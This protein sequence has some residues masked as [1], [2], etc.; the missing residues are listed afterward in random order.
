MSRFFSEKYNAL[1]AYTPGEQPKDMQYVKLNTNESPFPP[2]KKAKEYAAKALDRLQ[3]YCDPEC[4][5][6]TKEFAKLYGIGED[7]VVFTN[8]S[9]DALNFCFMAFCDRDTGAA[10]PDITYGFYPVF[11]RLNGV[12]YQEIPLRDDFTI[13]VDDYIGVNKTI[14]IANPNAPTGIALSLDDIER[15]L[16]GN[17]DNIVVV[18][19]AYVDFGAQSAVG[20]I[21]SYDN[22]I[23]TQTFSKSRSL[24]GGRL[25]MAIA[26][27]DLIRDLNT[28]KYSTNPYNINTVTQAAGVGTLL[29]D[30]Y[31]RRCCSTIADNRVYLTEKL[32]ELGFACTPS[33]SNFVFAKHPSLDGGMLYRRLKEKGVL[34]RHF[35]KPRLY[36]HNRIT[37]GTKEQIDVLI[38][39]IIEITEE[40][41]EDR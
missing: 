40:Q 38:E 29:D 21:H 37:V 28:I 4:T 10:F 39:K 23:V 17:P 7:E 26:N 27:R 33:V 12:D 6:L 13:N 25:G 36:D 3:L 5:A 31:I 22:L 14:F 19:E 11:A 2:S 18:D 32:G 34:I 24:A 30:E 16:Q 41:H 9:D 8:G 1:Q 15:I 20:L 35:D